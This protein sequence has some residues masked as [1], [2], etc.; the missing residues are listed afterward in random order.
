MNPRKIL[1]IH[2]AFIGDLILSTGFIRE[3]KRGFPEASIDLLTTPVSAELFQFNPYLDNVY[4]FAKRGI[5]GIFN[6][7]KLVQKLRRV[8]YDAAFSLHLSIRSSLI[9]KHAGIPVRIGHHR[10]S[11]LTHPVRVDRNMHIKDRYLSILKPFID[12]EPN[13]DT[14]L[15]PGVINSDMAG[16]IVG[17]DNVFNIGIAPGSI[18]NTKRWP[19]EYF[20]TLTRELAREMNIY[21]I[22]GPQDRA[23]CQ[24]IILKSEVKALNLAGKLSLL[25][26]AAVIEKL[27]LLLTN[28]SAPLHMANAVNTS[29][30]ALYGPTVRDFG[31]YPYRPD[32]QIIEVQLACRPCGKH[33]GKRCPRKNFKCML[34]ITPAIVLQKIL[35]YRKNHATS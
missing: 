21:F 15:H 12:F 19:Q 20:V 33:G 10:M 18:R 9:M 2:T 5:K 4:S 31:Y 24:E 22:G 28:D 16:K 6:Q 8:G 13:S 34:N 14:E 17:K 35:E 11:F 26:S 1:I 27:N 7:I 3:V 32:D 25:G 30:L 23:L 29:V